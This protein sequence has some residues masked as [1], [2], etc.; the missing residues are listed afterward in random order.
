MNRKKGF[1]KRSKMRKKQASGDARATHTAPGTLHSLKNAV[2]VAR[3]SASVNL[4]NI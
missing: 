2:R 4:C 1:L 3:A